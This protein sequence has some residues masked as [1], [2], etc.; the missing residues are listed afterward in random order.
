MITVL[1]LVALVFLLPVLGSIIAC[2]LTLFF[3]ALALVS[4]IVLGLIVG[5]VK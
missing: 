2:T 3:S 4:N 1:I 5:V